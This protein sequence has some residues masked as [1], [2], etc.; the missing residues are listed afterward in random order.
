[1]MRHAGQTQ[2]GAGMLMRDYIGHAAEC[3]DGCTFDTRVG[4]DAEWGSR[5]VN[6]G[7]RDVDGYGT[8]EAAEK[9][10]ALTAKY[11]LPRYEVVRRVNGVWC[12]IW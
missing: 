4:R 2:S 3:F 12:N 7:F 10:V 1:M 5:A 9:S 11:N 6:G 8:R